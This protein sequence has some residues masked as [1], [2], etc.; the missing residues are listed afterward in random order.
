MMAA[1]LLGWDIGGAHVKAVLLAPDGRV[2]G[3]WHRAAPLWRGLG[4]MADAVR[5]IR[6][7]ARAAD[8]HVVTMTGELADLFAGREEGVRRIGGCLA[9]ALAP[10]PVRYFRPGRG[11]AT[12]PGPEAAEIASMNWLAAAEYAAGRVADAVLVD[13]GS[14][15]ADLTLLQDGRV[16]PAGRSDAERLVSRTLVYTGVARTSLMSLAR[17]VR[18]R[19]A[20]HNV[21][22]EHFATTADV[23]NLLDLLPEALRPFET[24]DGAGCSAPAS[25]RRLAR[26]VGEDHA[27][28]APLEPW[29]MLA[30]HYAARQRDLLANNLRA[31]LPAGFAGP[32]IGAGSGRFAL[33]AVAARCGLVYRDIDSLLPAAP[34]AAAGLADCLPAYAVA[35]LYRRSHAD[36]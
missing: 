8:R 25:A 22:A 23:Y 4:L 3:V 9:A 14:T 16:R 6:G 29:R 30:A 15:T 17:R 26:M 20:W 36:R 35:E 11:F 7:E 1:P 12:E 2:G 24:A 21:M 13:L 28:G 5:A 10:E 19:G 31:A 34:P 32:L 18:V 33:P 27:A